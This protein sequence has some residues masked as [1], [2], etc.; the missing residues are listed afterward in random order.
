MGAPR[1][2]TGSRRPWA[3]GAASTD[4]APNRAKPSRGSTT[5]VVTDGSRSRVRD[6]RRAV[7][8]DTPGCSAHRSRFVDCHHR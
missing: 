5:M 2:D 6:L 3:A 1:R 7:G 4:S 8:D